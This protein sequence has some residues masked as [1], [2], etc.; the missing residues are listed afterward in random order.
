MNRRNFLGLFSAGV[1]GIALKQAIP[2]GRVWS[3][4]SKIVIRNA[5]FDP[6]FEGASVT[7]F[8]RWS[9]DQLH[10][11]IWRERSFFRED[12]ALIRLGKESIA[13]DRLDRMPMFVYMEHD[14]WRIVDEPMRKD[15][16]LWPEKVIPV[17]PPELLP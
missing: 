4:P 1:A 17:V 7:V 9:Y 5:G 16:E 8:E 14:Q 3:F 12:G 13:W 6:A 15:F 2:L 11:R 10:H